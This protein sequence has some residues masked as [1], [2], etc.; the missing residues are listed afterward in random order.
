M[1]TVTEKRSA[2]TQKHENSALAIQVNAGKK[3]NVRVA[4]Y[5]NGIVLITIE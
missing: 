2:T 1:K 4:Q 5:S 3:S